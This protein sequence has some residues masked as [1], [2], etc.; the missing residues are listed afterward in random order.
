MTSK[1][2]DVQCNQHQ[3]AKG[4]DA[5]GSLIYTDANVTYTMDVQ[6]LKVVGTAAWFVGQVT[7]FEVTGHSPGLRWALDSH[8]GG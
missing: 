4:L 1:P 6:Y 7:S 5:K 8:Q 2:T 3:V